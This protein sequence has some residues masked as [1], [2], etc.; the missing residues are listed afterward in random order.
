M[1]YFR[2]YSTDICVPNGNK[3][4]NRLSGHDLRLSVLI[5]GG[6]EKTIQT[7]TGMLPQERFRLLTPEKTASQTRQAI[8]EGL[9]DIII[10][11][12]PL[13]DES[14]WQL[15]QDLA[16]NETIGM[17]LFVSAQQYEAVQTSLISA[18]IMI[19]S[20]PVSRQMFCQAINLLA[21]AAFRMKKLQ[22]RTED[23]QTK[24]QEL[25]AVN[26]AKLLLMQQ[27]N[28][29]EAQA[30]RII[31]KKAMDSCTRR[32]NVAEQIIRSF[33]DSQLDRGDKP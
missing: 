27:L 2:S 28:I 3:G 4:G 19:L 21:A 30:H 10:L 9:V 12:P 17:L 13:P 25:R 31:E 20:R 16:A 24:I 11:S 32:L 5:A 29:T 33:E 8:A 14:V 15:V 7:L 18:G 1:R 22:A 6:S 26:R 23:L